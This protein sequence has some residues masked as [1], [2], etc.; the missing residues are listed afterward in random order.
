MFMATL[1][2]YNYMKA[3]KFEIGGYIGLFLGYALLQ[4]PDLCFKVMEW[5]E[6][7]FLVKTGGSKDI[8]NTGKMINKQERSSVANHTKPI[9]A[10]NVYVPDIYSKENL[11]VNK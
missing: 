5:L 7:T 10:K 11:I 1:F 6:Q 9:L 4:T 8:S 3:Y 2:Y